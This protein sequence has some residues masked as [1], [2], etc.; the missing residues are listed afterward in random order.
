MATGN[1][2]LHFNVVMTPWPISEKLKETESYASGTFVVFVFSIAFAL[3]PASIIA[4]ICSE[5]ERNLKH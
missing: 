3:L 2:N 5:K 4:F 1:K